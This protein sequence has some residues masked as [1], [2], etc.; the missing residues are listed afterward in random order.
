M[1]SGG[2]GEGA[3]DGVAVGLGQTGGSC[4]GG[5]RLRRRRVRQCGMV[6]DVAKV[7]AKKPSSPVCGLKS[8]DQVRMG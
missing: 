5:R 8:R 6:E 7:L 4:G 3:D 1:I 2:I